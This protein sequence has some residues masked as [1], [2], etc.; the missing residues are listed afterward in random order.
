YKTAVFSNKL[1]RENFLLA[2]AYNVV[3]VAL[4]VLGFV[5][6][7]VAAIAMSGSSLIVIANSFRLTRMR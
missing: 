6:P 2:V 5:T 7:L 4:A 3:A 1:V